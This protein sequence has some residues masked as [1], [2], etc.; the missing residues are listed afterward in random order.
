MTS[1]GGETTVY[2]MTSLNGSG[3]SHLDSSGS[4]VGGHA[5]PLLSGPTATDTGDAPLNAAPPDPQLLEKATRRRFTSAYK[6]SIIAKADAC[7][8][9]GSLG[10]LLRKEGLFHSTLAKF[11]TQNRQ[12]LLSGSSPKPRP[13][14]SPTVSASLAQQ[15]QLEREN[16]AL[17]RKLARAERIIAIQKKV[18]IL[19]GETFQD[20][21]LEDET[22]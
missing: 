2:S 22:D 3:L 8:D 12:G 14:K 11:R 15:S 17:R 7:S 20:I 9:R 16:R 21:D 1:L 19:L 6:L 18:A 10:A 13:E 5:H 4:A